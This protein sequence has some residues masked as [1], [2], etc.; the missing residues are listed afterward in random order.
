MKHESSTPV[1]AAEHRDLSG[2]ALRAFFNI[3]ERWSLSTSQQ[4]VLLGNPP[5]S[6]Y[7]KW[8][9]TKSG[10][11]GRDVLE[12]ISSILGIYKALEILLPTPE[13]AVRRRSHRL[14]LLGRA[15]RD[16]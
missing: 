12:R 14:R 1:H 10:S 3:A 11:L 15:G 2:P 8:K 16:S 9:K 6:T 7:F 4:R 13:H 5:A